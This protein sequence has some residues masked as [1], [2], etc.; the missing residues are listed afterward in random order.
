MGLQRR[1]RPRPRRQHILQ[2]AT[3]VRQGD[4]LGPLLLSLAIRPLLDRLSTFLGTDHLVLAYLDDVYVLSPT[5]DLASASE[6]A[7][8]LEKIYFRTSTPY[9][10]SGR[11][12]NKT[13][14]I[15]RGLSRITP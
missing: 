10:F 5:Q 4:P 7:S 12:F 2:S 9:S 15:F 11:V 6:F 3:G 14:A 8:T 1:F 13:S